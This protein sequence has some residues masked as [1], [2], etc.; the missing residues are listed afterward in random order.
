MAI[1]HNNIIPNVHFRKWW[2]RRV[3]TWFN[4]AGRKKSRRVARQ[5]K[6]AAVF[7]RPVAGLLRPAVRPQTRRYNF[8]LRAGR[9]FTLE[10]I[11]KAGIPVKG[12]KSLGICVD[13]R[14]RN[15]CQ[16]SLD[17]NAA[18]L[19]EYKSKMVLI[20]RKSKAKKGDTERKAL[21]GMTL[22]QAKTKE[23][24][25]IKRTLKRTKAE[26]ITDEM[27]K[28]SAYRVIR[29]ARAWERQ[30]GKR[31]KKAEEKALKEKNK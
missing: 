27:K 15:K 6:A 5:K 7:P 1:K 14:R 17:L 23:I 3:R 11:K 20:P 13:H 25:P 29:L 21:K 19:A 4:Q 28:T 10:E 30:L 26:K 16:E 18:R 31:I 2:Q 22:K 9:G 8:K 12:A 24:V